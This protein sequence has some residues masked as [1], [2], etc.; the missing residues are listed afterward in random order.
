MTELAIA[1]DLGGTN[2]R[3]SVIDAAGEMRFDSR[4]S[5][6]G[7]EGVDA[8]IGRIARMIE[9]AASDQ[10]LGP[11][12][13]VGVVA[14]GPLDTRRGIVRYAPN[15]PGWNEVPLRARLEQLTG[16]RIILGNDANSQAL[17]EHI[18]GAAKDVDNLVYI[19]LGTG[20]GGGVIANGKLV[21]GEAGLGGELGHMTINFQ[22][23]RCT[24]GSLGCVEAY[25][26]GWAIARDGQALADSNRSDYLEA[27]AAQRPVSS[28]D[29]NA[30]AEA[31][32]PLAAAVIRDA[33]HALGAAL[34]NFVNMFNPQI[35]VIGG[36]LAQIGAR[37]LDPAYETMK[38]FALPDLTE[39]L[40]IRRSAL[41]T[42][43]GLYGAAALVLFQDKI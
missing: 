37:L 6:R 35:I 40:E 18:F 34:G 32:D 21:D 27:I 15:L 38:R 7:D 10:G 36:G 5:S 13:A 23:P 14:P 1:V 8:V 30:A 16:R 22:G 25:C 24:C 2:L 17:A 19:A 9:V 33:G 12:V 41:G 39:E 43:T 26:S 11:E 4:Q 42:H 3:C 31:G 29:V 28:R 20:L